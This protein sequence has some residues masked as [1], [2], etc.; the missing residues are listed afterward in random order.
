MAEIVK[1]D[2]GDVK[3][4]CFSCKH[5]AF[6]NIWFEPYCRKKECKYEAEETEA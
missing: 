1:D 6:E 3:E 4:P 5:L 2:E